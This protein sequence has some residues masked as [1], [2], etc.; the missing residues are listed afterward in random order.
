MSLEIID[1]SFFVDMTEEE[2]FLHFKDKCNIGTPIKGIY[3]AE[4]K[5]IEESVRKAKRS[6]KK[7]KEAEPDSTDS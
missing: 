1:F 3:R 2:F 4:K 5:K 6:N 7:S